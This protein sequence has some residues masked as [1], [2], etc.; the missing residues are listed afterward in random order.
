V[1]T[2]RG[3]LIDVIAG[4]AVRA[5]GADA[6]APGA[7]ED[8]ARLCGQYDLAVFAVCGAAALQRFTA[9]AFAVPVVWCT[10]VG[11]TSHARLRRDLAVIRSASIPVRGLLLWD[12]ALPELRSRS[13]QMART[14]AS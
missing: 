5:A 13:D 11:A 6:S 2:R 12:E 8:V 14:R 10:R 9:A 1:G 7:R 4:V 3:L